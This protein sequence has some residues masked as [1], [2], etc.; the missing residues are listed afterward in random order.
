MKCFYLAAAALLA[1]PLSAADV[2]WSD[3]TIA[4]APAGALL[5][6]N[7]GF[8]G[9][10]QLTGAAYRY[11]GGLEAGSGDSAGDNSPQRGRR[12]QNGDI[13][14]HNFVFKEALSPLL[15]APAAVEFDF[16]QRCVFTEVDL[17]IAPGNYTLTLSAGDAPDALTEVFSGRNFAVGNAM[18]VARF[19]LDA[20]VTAR[21]L[22]F[23]IAAEAGGPVALSEV[24]AWGERLPSVPGE[25]PA[26]PWQVYDISYHQGVPGITN[27]TI[28]A[29]EFRRWRRTLER[30]FNPV[31]AVI[32]GEVAA[33]DPLSKSAVMPA[34]E[35]A[36]RPVELTM[37]RNGSE[38]AAL[39]LASSYF[40]AA[41]STEIA[42]SE[43]RDASGNAA[44][45]LAGEIMVFGALPSRDF[46]VQLTVLI[47]E[48]NK[49]GADVLRRYCTNGG[50]IAEFPRIELNRA[51]NLFCWLKVVADGCAPGRYTAELS[52]GGA[53]KPV[54]VRVLD[55]MLE[56][57]ARYVNFWW[58]PIGQYPFM[59]LDWNA[60]DARHRLEI[61]AT[62]LP[63]RSL[64]GPESLGALMQAAQPRMLFG[65]WQGEYG[66]RLWAAGHMDYD[67]GKDGLQQEDVAK[68]QAETRSIADF[69]KRRG[70]NFDQ[71]FFEMADEPNRRNYRLFGEIATAMH[72]AVPEALITC[73][74]CSWQSAAP[75]FE[76]DGVIYPLIKEW[77]AREVNI[78][79]PAISLVDYPDCGQLFKAP[80]KYN[81]FYEVVTSRAK[82]E[83]REN[84]NY[85]RMLVWNAI[86]RNFNSWNMFAYFDT[87]H[88]ES[89][90]DMG[91]AGLGT[92]FTLVYPGPNGPVPT[93][94]FE[95]AREGFQDYLL[96]R[97]VE[98]RNPAAHAAIIAEFVAGA[99][100]EELREM[101]YAAL[102]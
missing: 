33:W 75:H 21:Y 47:S 8:Y 94:Q 82:S 49:P 7:Q 51:G 53:V 62:V 48:A 90:D 61:G 72:Q 45:G 36:A 78:S 96:M 101:I 81:G 25:E 91:A 97:L 4:P 19:I 32:W 87:A 9:D 30:A 14:N 57:E 38:A 22:V 23:A 60:S 44:E 39:V 20:P 17:H 10:V 99:S 56:D 41:V 66:G 5:S 80:R 58:K 55:A 98:R 86:R 67:W 11:L 15:S 73:N 37:V 2:R 1:A 65:F 34:P 35:N 100:Y 50:V 42:L 29:G 54:E 84:V 28:D 43:F 26:P 88:F 64:A 59:P 79:L 68:I 12:L 83:S 76:P 24:Y 63:E 69:A 93:R 70:L 18:T 102:E 46:G 95:A 77:Y 3:D 52:A 31:P 89:W 27:T 71:W 16:R 74:P 85:P 6:D 13:G 92:S 40:D